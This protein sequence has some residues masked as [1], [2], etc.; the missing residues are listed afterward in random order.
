MLLS[1]M[2]ETDEGIPIL[3]DLLLGLNT[4]EGEDERMYILLLVDFPEPILIPESQLGKWIAH[5]GDA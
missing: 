3:D 4:I 5:V 1:V 2:D